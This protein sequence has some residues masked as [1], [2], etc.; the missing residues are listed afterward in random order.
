M[1]HT[2]KGAGTEGGPA[3][4][5]ETSKDEAAKVSKLPRLKWI[6]MGRGFIVLYMVI[7]IIFPE[8]WFKGNLVLEFLFVH[9]ARTAFQMHLI[10]VGA[11][12]FVFI[13]GLL[14]S[15]SFNRRR[16]SHG[17]GKAI[18]HIVKRYGLILLLGFLIVLATSDSL[19]Y[20]TYNDL[21]DDGTDIIVLAWDVIPALGLVGFI[22]IPF[23][24][25]KKKY[26]LVAGY[27]WMAFY[28]IML[29]LNEYTQWADR[30]A[31]A[32]HGGILFGIFAF[33]STQIIASSV[34]EYIIEG[35][36]N[37]DRTKV[38]YKQLAMFGSI[39]LGLGFCMLPF[40]TTFVPGYLLVAIS[41]VI[42][43]SSG[44]IYLDEVKK[45]DIPFL[46]AY[47]VNPFFVYL[48]TVLPAFIIFDF[49]I[50]GSLEL[51]FMNFLFVSGFIA[52]QM[53]ILLLLYKKGKIIKTEI[54]S[55]IGIGVGL[56]LWAILSATGFI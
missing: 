15:T 16:E 31:S 39:N 45:K 38:M 21:A 11:T 55:L 24:F 19:I 27:C 37:K 3:A 49:I 22:G 50:P 28:G 51:N 8:D 35:K 46:S 43:G 48:I 34:G 4:R 36:R 44:F 47:G 12:G 30:A 17:V 26:R 2:E 40:Q 52:I 14:F 53:V 10:D 29:A 7:S 23:L 56:G 20:S 41:T 42:L 33:G 13:L 54:V 5:H 32:V 1:I 9:P 18:I 6:D 25:L